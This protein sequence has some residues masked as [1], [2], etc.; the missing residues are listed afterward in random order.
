[1]LKL[2]TGACGLVFVDCVSLL[3]NFP[4][5]LILQH[6]GFHLSVLAQT[7]VGEAIVDGIR[8]SSVL[9]S[10]GNNLEQQRVAN[11]GGSFAGP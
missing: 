6:D 7:I 1:L 5:R 10:A 3:T 4:K 2:H 8:S 9:S 11:V